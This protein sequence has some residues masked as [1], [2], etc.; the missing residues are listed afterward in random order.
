[1]NEPVDEVKRFDSE[2]ALTY[3]GVL[4]TGLVGGLGA[5]TMQATPLFPHAVGLA[6]AQLLLFVYCIGRDNDSNNYYA[7]WAQALVIGALLILVP[8]DFIFILTVVWIVQAVEL[9]G[10]RAAAWFLAAALVFFL[11]SQIYHF[12]FSQPITTTVSVALYGLLNMFAAA[13]VQRFVSERKQKEF[14]AALNR[15]LIATRDLLSQSTAQGERLRIARDLHDI[16][17]HHMTALILNLE[18][19]SHSTEGAPKEKVDQ[20]LAIAKM[21]I[22]DL[23]STVSEFRDE[24]AINL[25]ESIK[26]LV[27]GI[28]SFD[29]E[30]DFS[31]A[32][33]IEDMDTAETLLRCTQEAVTNVLR[34]SSADHCRIVMAGDEERY[35]L[36]VI[37]NG[38]VRHSITPGN[39]LTGMMERVVARG[40]Q[41]DW[42]QSNEGF[43]VQVTMGA[44]ASQ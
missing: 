40:G 6:L 37:D 16:L 14:T 28:P 10:G 3:S 22:G 32:P 41:L 43:R 42:Q 9:Y 12:G 7:F 31:D 24:A 13:V 29:I 38:S 26:K 17:G 5:W 8:S 27:S 1:M 39:G 34:H 4:V 36:S 21:L 15:E 33:T 11:A 30:V 19:A 25:E 20:S 35:T 18:V 2:Q 44:T 23:R